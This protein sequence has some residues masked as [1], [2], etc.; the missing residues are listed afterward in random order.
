M[1]SDTSS[2]TASSSDPAAIGSDGRSARVG[3][4]GTVWLIG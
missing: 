2:E 1:L 3:V 4:G